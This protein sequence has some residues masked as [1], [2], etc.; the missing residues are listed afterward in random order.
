MTHIRVMTASLTAADLQPSLAGRYALKE[1]GHFL[2]R[3]VMVR[4]S[5]AWLDEYP[6]P[7]QR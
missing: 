6:G 3:P 7:V 1:G 5:L 2:P 4:E